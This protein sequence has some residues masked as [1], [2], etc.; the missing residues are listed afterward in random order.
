MWILF[1]IVLNNSQSSISSSNAKFSSYTSCMQGIEK[2]LEME[3]MFGVKIQA[4]C[5]K[6]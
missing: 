6:E 3:K 5:V 2:L 4:R 1:L